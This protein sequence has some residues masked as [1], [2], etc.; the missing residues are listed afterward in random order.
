VSGSAIDIGAYEVQ[1]HQVV[2]A[3]AFTG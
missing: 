3:P 2:I 1:V